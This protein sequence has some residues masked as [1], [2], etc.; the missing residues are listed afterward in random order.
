MKKS[1]PIT[2]VLFTISLTISAILFLQSQTCAQSDVDTIISK[3]ISAF[4]KQKTIKAEIKAHAIM[5][6]NQINLEL[7]GKGELYIQRDGN[8]E[9]YMQKIAAIP[10]KSDESLFNNPIAQAQIIFDGSE[11]YVTYKLMA[12]QQTIKTP[13][14]ITKGTIAPGGK[15]LFNT[16]KEKLNISVLPE[17]EWE[18]KKMLHLKLEPKEPNNDFSHVQLLMDPQLGIIRKI[19]IVGK[20]QNTLF[21]CEYTN[22]QTNVEIPAGT[23]DIPATTPAPTS[24]TPPSSPQ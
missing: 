12:T 18:G 1:Y 19:T 10:M 14:D 5:P 13:P 22:I 24:A 16:L 21:T 3:L 4:E 23:F 11:Y 7:K 20:D 9:K 2:I 8:S 6:M 17:E 15:N